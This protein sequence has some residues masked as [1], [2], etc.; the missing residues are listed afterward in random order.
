MSTALLI[1][2]SL[3][4][5]AS[6]MLLH[7]ETNSLTDMKNVMMEIKSIMMAVVRVAELNLTTI[8]CLAE[9]IL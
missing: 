5:H 1:K 9:T 3:M 4:D 2:L 8:V 6:A 7:A